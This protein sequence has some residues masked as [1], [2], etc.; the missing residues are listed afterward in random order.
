MIAFH[1]AILFVP[2]KF[3]IVFLLCLFSFSANAESFDHWLNTF[4]Q[5]AMAAGVSRDVL[6]YAL[7][8]VYLDARVIK[9]DR[10]QPEGHMTLQEYVEKTVT[11]KRVSTGRTKLQQHI[12]LLKKV[13]QKYGVSPAILIALWGK[14]T[15]FGGYTGNFN[16]INSLA[17][18]AYEG[19]RRAY[20]EQELLE[21]IY[22]L[23]RMGWAPSRMTGSWAG[24]VG[25]CQFMP[26]NYLRIA[27][28]GDGNGKTD[29]WNSMSDVFPSMANL[30]VMNGWRR[31]EGWGQKIVMP[32]RFDKNLIGRDKSPRDFHF[33]EQR[34]VRF[35][36]PVPVGTQH[37]IRLY[38]PDSSDGPAY[39]IYPN[40]D[41]LMRWNRSGYFATAVGRLADNISSSTP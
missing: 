17:T 9:L 21:A 5:R 27:I 39:A 37:T 30:L 8:D 24:A 29:L 15:D 25:Q 41:V 4:K 7:R 2:M 14:E 11:P 12:A 6:D 16:T 28:D 38:Q 22:L 36:H 10:K 26:S 3:L 13:E 35:K 18:L 32:A 34:G 20:F 33:W 23:R 40:F 1:A 19:R 31:G